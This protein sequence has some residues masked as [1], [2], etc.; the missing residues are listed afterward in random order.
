MK[1][2]KKIVAVVLCLIITLSCFAIQS[3]AKEEKL[4]YLVIGDS[5]AEGF[6]VTNRD[7]C[8]FGKIVA[9][10]NG[11]NYRN[12]AHM[13]YDSEDIYNFLT[14][15]ETYIDSVEWADIITLSVGGNNFLLDNAPLLV[16]SGLV[17]YY[18]PFD[19]RAE[20]FNKYFELSIEEIH[21]LNPDAVVLVQ[22]L[23]NTWTTFA[24]DIFQAAADRIN[25][26]IYSYLEKNPGSYYIVDTVESFYKNPSLISSDTVHPN[27][28]GNIVLA[29]LTLEKLNEIGLGEATEPVLLVEGIDRDYIIE[30]FPFPIGHILTFLANLATGNMFHK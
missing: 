7:E 2:I 12:L 21:R 3:S 10:T 15:R 9:D 17:G 14:T 23:Y 26:E 5:I 4:N 28:A 18:A 20:R 30:Y 27:T 29:R 25:N 16:F 19:E 24:Y 13:G 6:G 8:A 22:T 1:T 11:Y